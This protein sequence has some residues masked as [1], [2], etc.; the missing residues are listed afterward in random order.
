M[1]CLHKA[2]Q[3]VRSAVVTSDDGSKALRTFCADCSQFVE[4]V[5]VLDRDGLVAVNSWVP[6]GPLYDEM[7]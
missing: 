4:G 1:T 3:V 7:P 5:P 6:I 2:A